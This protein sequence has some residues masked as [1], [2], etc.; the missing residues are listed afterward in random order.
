MSSKA[1]QIRRIDSRASDAQAAL[2][3]LRAALSPRGNVVSEE[4]SRRTKEVFGAE[5]TPQEVVER[6]CR[7][8]REKGLAAVLDYSARI[9]KAALSAET[10]RVEHKPSQ[11][12]AHMGRVLEH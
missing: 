1:M 11:P 10:I 8:V 4:G 7:D 5:L 2:A 3:S 6:I 12:V 9:D